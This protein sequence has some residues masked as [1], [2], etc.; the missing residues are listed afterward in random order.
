M[1][2]FDAAIIGGGVIGCSIARELAGS[3]LSVVILERSQPGSQATRASVGCIIGGSAEEPRGQIEFLMASKSL[4][5]SLLDELNDETGIDIECYCEGTLLLAFDEFDN[6]SL[7]MIFN[8]HTKE[9]GLNIN[10]RRLGTKDVLKLEPSVSPKVLSAIFYPE[11]G[12]VNNVKLGRALLK[13]AILRG[14]HLMHATAESLLIENDAVLG[15]EILSGE[16]IFAKWIINAAGAWADMITGMPKAGIVPAKGQTITMRTYTGETWF[17]HVLMSPSSY[18][19][20]RPDGELRIG[21]TV[22]FV[23][24]DDRSTIGT[25]AQIAMGAIQI[26]PVISD[27]TFL[28]AVSGFRPCSPDFLPIIGFSS[29]LKNL[30]FATAHHRYGITLAPLTAKIIASLIL[31]RPSPFEY[32]KYQANRFN[33]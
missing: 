2:S 11:D 32:S 26:S 8:E 22:E 1:N 13:S 24:F 12:Q 18:I 19:V 20:P 6:K 15:V 16:K 5:P 17:K 27:C 10:A 28:E 4:F 23:G 33:V 7:D 30:L 25:I 21:T 9:L 29:C 31:N 14:A 3:G